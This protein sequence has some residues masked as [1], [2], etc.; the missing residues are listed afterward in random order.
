[1]AK[2]S[3]RKLWTEFVRNGKNRPGRPA[4][5]ARVDRRPVEGLILGVDPSL[6][7]TGLALLEARG[8][9]AALL[10]SEVLRFPSAWKTADCLGGISRRVDQLLQDHPVTA[11]AV[12]EAIYVQNYRTALILG[13]ARGALIA[14]IVLRGVPIHEYPPLRIKQALVGYGRASKEQ[15]RRTLCQVV[16]GATETLSLDESDATAVAAC[17]WMTGRFNEGA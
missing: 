7:G 11:A 9:T 4:L 2:Q 15:V 16:G 5:P 12:E 10:H 3:S 8:A 6:R 17:Y 13:A 14:A 1:M